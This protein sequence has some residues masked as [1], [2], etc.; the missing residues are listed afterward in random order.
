M[1]WLQNNYSAMRRLTV[2][3][4][5]KRLCKS[6]ALDAWRVSYG[7]YP[8]QILLTYSFSMQGYEGVIH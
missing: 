8:L 2:I 5:S 4:G 1:S 7:P 6:E 3:A